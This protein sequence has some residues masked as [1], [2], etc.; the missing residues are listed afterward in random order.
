M[1]ST[2]INKC[3]ITLSSGTLLHTVFL[4]VS[5]MP[6]GYTTELYNPTASVSVLLLYLSKRGRKVNTFLWVVD[7]T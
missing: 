1:N 3:E 6:S 4:C 7:L 2:I 5:L